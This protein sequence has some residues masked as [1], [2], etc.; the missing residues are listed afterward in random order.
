MW[1]LSLSSTGSSRLFKGRLR[2]LSLTS[3]SGHG[4]RRP[5]LPRSWKEPARGMFRSSWHPR[6]RLPERSSRG[7][8]RIRRV[9]SPGRS[10]RSRSPTV[11]NLRPWDR[12]RSRNNRSWERPRLGGSGNRRPTVLRGISQRLR[13]SFHLRGYSL[14]S[15]PRPSRG[16]RNRKA[17]TLRGTS[18]LLSRPSFHMFDSSSTS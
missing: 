1:F 15:W 6:S 14:T 10:R 9:R 7:L 16:S 18:R 5:S 3:L 17:T 8:C 4:T 13:R 11:S 12:S 2:R